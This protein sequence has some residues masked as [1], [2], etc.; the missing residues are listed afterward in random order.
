MN[1]TVQALAQVFTE[2]AFD[3]GSKGGKKPLLRLAQV[4]IPS[5]SRER[6]NDLENAFTERDI[7]GSKYSYLGINQHREDY[8]GADPIPDCVYEYLIN[9]P[10]IVN[11]PAMIENLSPEGQ[12]ITSLVEAFFEKGEMPALGE[13]DVRFAALIRLYGQ[14]CEMHEVVKW[15]AGTRNDLCSSIYEKVADFAKDIGVKG[16][17]DLEHEIRCCLQDVNYMIAISKTSSGWYFPLGLKELGG[18]K[19]SDLKF[20]EEFNVP[21]EFTG[22]LQSVYVDIVDKLSA[23]Q[24]F[25]VLDSFHYFCENVLRPFENYHVMAAEAQ[26]MARVSPENDNLIDGEDIEHTEEE[27]EAYMSYSPYNDWGTVTAL[28]Y[29]VYRDQFLSEG[30]IQALEPYIELWDMCDTEN[31]NLTSLT[32]EQARSISMGK[33]ALLSSQLL[34]GH[35]RFGFSSTAEVDV[36]DLDEFRY[37]IETVP[38]QTFG[39]PINFL[40]E[41]RDI[42][43]KCLKVYNFHKK[44]NGQPLYDQTPDS[45]DNDNGMEPA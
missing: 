34:Y 14:C 13:Q 19:G 33:M 9:Y 18:Q 35:N 25:D 23:E 11:V 8:Y 16:E 36:S 26:K 32:K 29:S 43:Q 7:E 17:T 2:L 30:S 40:L 4:T 31:P 42:K 28:F 12:R 20:F 45:F 27:V 15:Q 37:N 39:I 22:M 21:F 38:E 24:D 5:L 1:G 3:K 41:L 6:L 10:F 44:S